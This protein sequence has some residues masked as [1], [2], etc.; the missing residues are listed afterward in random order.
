[1]RLLLAL[2]A[3]VVLSGG[4]IRLAWD[5]SP[6]PGVTNYSV[7]AHTNQ[8]VVACVIVP[9]CLRTNVGTNL[10]V[11][12]VALRPGRWWFVAT[13]W[14]DGLESA[15]SGVLEVEEPAPPAGM[16]TLN[17]QASTDLTTW[18]NIGFFRL[19]LR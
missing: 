4:D 16:R 13:A 9:G 11:D 14:K 12:F 19:L 7:Y 5:A 18:T 2:L 17:V 3:T 15:P 8:I 10:V 1:M 6:T